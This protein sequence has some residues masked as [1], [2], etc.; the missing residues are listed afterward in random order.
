MYPTMP[1]AA[2]TLPR[3]SLPIEGMTCAACAGRAANRLRNKAPAL[4]G[5][6]ENAREMGGDTV[7]G[8]VPPLCMA[9]PA[10]AL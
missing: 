7:R 3:L 10:S 1:D 8:M 2:A 5:R 4:R 6:E 9:A